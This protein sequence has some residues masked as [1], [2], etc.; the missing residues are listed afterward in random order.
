MT[1][2]AGC[3]IYANTTPPDAHRSDTALA[4]PDALVIPDAHVLTDDPISC[5][6]P[7]PTTADGNFY[8]SGTVATS[9]GTGAQP[10][11]VAGASIELYDV[12][13]AQPFATTTTDHFGEFTID[14]YSLTPVHAY[15]RVSSPGYV[16]T[17]YYSARPWT[18]NLDVHMGVFDQ[19]TFAQLDDPAH[20][21]LYVATLDCYNDV[22]LGPTVTIDPAGSSVIDYPGGDPTRGGGFA[23][24]SGVTPGLVKVDGDDGS[25][26]MCGHVVDARAGVLTMVD[27][28]R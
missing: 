5:G 7:L 10:T 27:L 23:V 4:A 16:D 2:L 6:A 14:M 11:P 28:S 13:N 1:A 24:I 22:L 25:T 15:A 20:A 12:G 9:N 18:S 26:P 3:S 19:A 21:F 17:Y 8:V